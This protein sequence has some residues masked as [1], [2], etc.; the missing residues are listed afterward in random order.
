MPNSLRNLL[1]ESMLDADMNER[2]WGALGRRYS[3]REKY[4]KVFLAVFS[5]TS[6][7]ASWSIWTNYPAIWKVLLSLS[8]LVA[9]ALPILN[10]S[11]TAEKAVDQKSKWAKLLSENEILWAKLEKDPDLDVEREFRSIKDAMAQTGKDDATI[12]LDKGLRRQAYE[13]V[14]ALHK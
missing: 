14:S 8:A 9:I 2:Y 11:G 1:W 4:A 13:E 10:Y 7:I 6:A 5:S 12:P 3:G